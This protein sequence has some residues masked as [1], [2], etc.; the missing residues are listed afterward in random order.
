MKTIRWLLCGALFV[1]LGGMTI[2]QSNAQ[3]PSGGQKTAAPST[4]DVRTVRIFLTDGSV[5]SGQL[6]IDRF[7]VQTEFGTLVVPV[8][9]I[10]SITPGLDSQPKLSARI[11]RLIAELGSPDA[12]VRDAA[13]EE[14]LKLG[15]AV[16]K[17]LAPY[18]NDGNAERKRRVAE[19][20]EKLSEA[21]ADDDDGDSVSAWVPYDVVVTSGFTIAGHV[22]P[23]VFKLNSRY[24]SL[25]VG[26]ADVLRT[27]RE[28]TAKG[29]VVKRLSVSGDK[30]VQRGL[31]SSG[32]RVEAGDTITVSATGQIV[33]SPW[34]SSAITGPDGSANYGQYYS[35]VGGRPQVFYGG[36]LLARIGGGE[37]IKVGSRARFVARRSGLLEFG[38]ACQDDYAGNGY[39]YPGNYNLR[40]RVNPKTN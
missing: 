38:I 16:R 15:P 14:L 36:T 1:A 11:T 22:S 3:Q 25:T 4:A 30:L 2:P 13:R 31:Q 35:S 27:V 12:K 17:V 5:V 26:L 20:I 23:N 24:G 32:I 40:I 29:A 39:Y 34:G 6:S 33:M 10:L 28:G 37:F 19:I 21:I 18:A 9:R 7:N 8:S